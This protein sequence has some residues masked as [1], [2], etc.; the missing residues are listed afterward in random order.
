MFADLHRALADDCTAIYLDGGNTYKLLKAVRESGFDEKI[1]DFLSRGS[2]V[3]GYSAGSIICGRDIAGTTYGDENAVGYGDTRGLNL[4]QGWDI[5]CHY[6]SDAAYKRR[7]IHAFSAES[8]GTIALSDGCAVFVE[9]G[10]MTFIGTGIML[11]RSK[12]VCP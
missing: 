11:F 10:A 1:L 2:F 5:C 4:A 6:R 3:Y 7:R 9:S 8:K 12:E